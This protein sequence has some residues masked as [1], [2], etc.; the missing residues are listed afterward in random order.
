[1]KSWNNSQH[2]VFELHKLAMG[3]IQPPPPLFSEL[4]LD[5]SLTM[6]SAPPYTGKSLLLAAMIVSLDTC[7]PLFGRFSPPSVKRTL[8]FLQDAT[9]WDYAEQFRK[10]IRGYGLSR[11]QIELL[12]ANLIINRDVDITEP[13][14]LTKLEAWKEEFP[15]EVIVFDAF[16]TIHGMNE[17]DKAQMAFVMRRLK[18]IRDD[19]G[20]AVVFSHHDR[21]I[22]AADYSVLNANYRASGSHVI[23]AAV[24]FHFNLKRVANKITIETPKSRGIDESLTSYS[25]VEVDHPDGTALKLESLR[26]E[27]TRQ[28]K[29][30]IFLTEPKTRKDMVVFI[31]AS[32]PEMTLARAEKAVDND[33][34]LLFSYNKIERIGHGVWKSVVK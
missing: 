33:L 1:M 8:A 25:I 14:F 20:V 3:D 6:I 18:K 5:K 32:F 19:F 16:W 29:L 7:L 34:R 30:V 28:G 13:D 15:F 22:G 11:E 12:E 26:P 17:N 2:G 27:Q 21:K 9:T 24:D 23:S 10:V 4:L 31:K